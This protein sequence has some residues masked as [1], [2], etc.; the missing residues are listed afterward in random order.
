MTG[1]TANNTDRRLYAEPVKHP[2][3]DLGRLVDLVLHLVDTQHHAASRPHTRDA[4]VAAGQPIE[5]ET[6][7]SLANGREPKE[8]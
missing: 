6:A 5:N 3:P 1:R 2:E 7:R 8:Q 4:D